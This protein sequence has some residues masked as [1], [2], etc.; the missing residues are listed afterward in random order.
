[1]AAFIECNGPWFPRNRVRSNI[2][3]VWF[4]LEMS[5][6]FFLF[7]RSYVFNSEFAK[8]VVSH[9]KQPFLFISS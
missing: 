5:L 8:F 7:S 4:P 1:M 9:G 6:T 2:I 3:N